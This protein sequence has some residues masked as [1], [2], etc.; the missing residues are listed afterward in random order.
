MEPMTFKSE[1]TAEI[2]TDV[3]VKGASRLREQ[4]NPINLETASPLL[5][6]YNHADSVVFVWLIPLLPPPSSS[7][8]II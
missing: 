8:G 1:I 5:R 4:Q 3:S 6:P 7:L 2:R